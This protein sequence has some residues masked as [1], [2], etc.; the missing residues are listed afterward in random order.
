MS[1]LA[2]LPVRTLLTQLAPIEDAI[3]GTPT[4]IYCRRGS[5]PLDADLLQLVARERD[6]MTVPP[7]AT[8]AQ[9]VTHAASPDDAG[10]SGPEC[11]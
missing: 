8:P 2:D 4:C 7:S 5:R 3:A 9:N 6:I 11:V 1:D 10:T